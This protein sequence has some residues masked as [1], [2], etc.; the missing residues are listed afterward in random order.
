M[1]DDSDV[2][3]DDRS[4]VNKLDGADGTVV[5]AG[6]IFGGVHVHSGRAPGVPAPRE[7]PGDV[8]A[9]VGRDGELGRLDELLVEVETVSANSPAVVAIV[10]GTAGVGKTALVNHWGSS[11]ADRFPDGQLYVNL[12]GCDPDNPLDTVQAQAELLRSLGV[13]Q[14]PRG[15]DARAKHFRSLA[16]GRR[17]LVVLDNASSDEQ[18][19]PLLPGGSS[20]LVLV[21]SRHELRGLVSRDG[22]RRIGLGLLT[23][24]QSV[25][26]LRALIGVRVEEEP[27]AATAL[28]GLCA[29]LPLAL[30][31]VAELAVSN[32]D[33]PLAELVEEL[34]DERHRLDL[35]DAGSD[36][37]TAVRA[38]FSWS[39][40]GLDDET[41][42]VFRLLGLHSGRAF[43]INGVA[44]MADLD[45]ISAARA[46]RS[47]VRA[48]LLER[49]ENRRFRMHD[50]LRVYAL[51]LALAAGE[52]A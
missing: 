45:V 25:E 52:I 35:L 24:A 12:R 13:R 18:V 17:M 39:Y 11:H 4:I 34:A 9:F 32:H 31:I 7:L 27:D 20:C 47:L 23:E 26:L 38:V 19:R 8:N 16:A 6:W 46:L 30:R 33:V 1:Y 51:E 49:A 37:R 42:R 15:V 29:R 10:S 43:T 3:G 21:T 50:L 5:Q 36:L 28:A 41:A 40:H 2:R 48:H 44:A 22:A 14:M